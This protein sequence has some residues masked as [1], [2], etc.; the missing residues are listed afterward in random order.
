LTGICKVCGRLIEPDRL[1]VLPTTDRCIAHASTTRS[2]AFMVYPHKTGG[3]VCVIRNP[4]AEQI[5]IAKR[6]NRRA[7]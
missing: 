3:S 2:A 5:R 4:T 6:A 1:E 7:R